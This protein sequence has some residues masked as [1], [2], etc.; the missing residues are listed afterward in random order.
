MSDNLSM[1][2]TGDGAWIVVVSCQ[3]CCLIPRDQYRD[4]LRAQGW[5]VLLGLLAFALLTFVAA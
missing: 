3:G 5:A 2:S 4:Y 1:E